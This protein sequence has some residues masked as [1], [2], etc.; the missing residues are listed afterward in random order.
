MHIVSAILGTLGAIGCAAGAFVYLGFHGDNS[1]A[2]ATAGLVRL[3][4]GVPCLVVGALLLIAA[5]I[6]WVL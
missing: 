3:F 4:I 2:N 6:A 1:D 5:L